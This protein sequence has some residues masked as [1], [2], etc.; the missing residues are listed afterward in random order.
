MSN[1]ITPQQALAVIKERAFAASFPAN[2]H[3]DTEALAK[4][5]EQALTP[6]NETTE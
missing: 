4:I 2:V 5:V 1:Q 6:T 3:M